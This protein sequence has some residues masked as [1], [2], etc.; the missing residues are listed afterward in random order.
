MDNTLELISWSNSPCS[1]LD[2]PGKPTDSLA[3]GQIVGKLGF[4]V[5]LGFPR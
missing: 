3:F 5:D 1:T 4:N 2:H